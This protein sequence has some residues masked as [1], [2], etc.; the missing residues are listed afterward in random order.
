MA[1]QLRSHTQIPLPEYNKDTLKLCKSA[2]SKTHVV[3][4]A[5]SEEATTSSAAMPRSQVACKDR[6][7]HDPTPNPPG[8]CASA[9][10]ATQP[11]ENKE[12]IAPIRQVSESVLVQEAETQRSWESI[13]MRTRHR[14]R[15]SEATR[16]VRSN[17]T[18]VPLLP[19]PPTTPKK[20]SL[21]T[22]PP[23]LHHQS[24]TPGTKRAKVEW[25]ESLIS[26]PMTPTKPKSVYA[27]ARAALRENGAIVG[28]QQ[29]RAQLHS[30]LQA[31]W[32]GQHDSH[33]LYISGM[34][35]TGKTMLVRDVVRELVDASHVYINCVGLSH[36]QHI[37]AQ[38]A[39]ALGVESLTDETTWPQT[40]VPP[41]PLVIVIDEMDLLLHS[42]AHQ[43]LLHRLFCLPKQLQNYAPVALI[44]IANSLDLT[45]RFVPLL[46]SKG[47]PPSMLHFAPLQADQVC[48]LLTSRLHMTPELVS[49]PA[50]QLLSRK[51]TATSGDIRRAL[52]ACRQALELAESDQL[53]KGGQPCVTPTHILR[54]LAHMTGNA[55][56]ARIR[57]L[58]V[59][60]K[61]LLL[62][63]VILQQQA[64][65]G[66]SKE[67]TRGDGG[68]LLSDL[69]MAYA[70]MLQ[71]DA[72]FV[73]PLGNSEL[74]DVL[75]R[76]EVQGLIRMHAE[77]GGGSMSSSYTK[78]S[79]RTSAAAPPAKRLSPSA[80]RAAAKQ[81]L[82]TNRR[83]APTV[84]RACIVRALTSGAESGS[85]SSHTQTV[86]DAMSRLLRHADNDI[87]RRTVWRN[88][89]A[90]RAR[91]RREELG[92]GRTATSDL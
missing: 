80:K 26:P 17:A 69:E 92:G 58:G 6:E 79:S 32:A 66:L 13:A 22:P 33:C 72:A 46:R 71:Q 54:V 3:E 35:G 14:Q 47:I 91:T 24:D 27:Q 49:K 36:P 28:R 45:E 15:A 37:E 75:E 51:L 67:A 20:R 55:Q 31:C 64:A 53:T 21:P 30:F 60:A 77:M 16:A 82:S 18:S 34:P 81:M 11:D 84:D 76:L 39:H 73:S 48:E 29:E 43:A 90:D 63:W 5:G 86:V 12:N 52:D 78:T 61:L 44:G 9:P 25:D 87:A 50:L 4:A 41:K 7:P 62:A 42:Q 40:S 74:L 38:W 56:M 65:S 8:S 57:S 23:S 89:E 70:G 2:R 59:H 10:A 88:E 85:E 19:R 83:I 68:V 1:M